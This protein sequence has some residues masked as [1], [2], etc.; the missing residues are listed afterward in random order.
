MAKLSDVSL[1][2][3]ARNEAVRLFKNDPDLK[4]VENNK[5]AEE[6][7]RVWHNTSNEVS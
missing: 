1:L 3:L 2:E 6:L 7:G 4:K 5:L